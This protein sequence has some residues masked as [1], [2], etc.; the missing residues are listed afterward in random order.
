VYAEL[1]R[2]ARARGT[3]I[4][5]PRE[6]CGKPR[7]VGGATIELL[8]PCPAFVPGRDANDNSL[9]MRVAFGRRTV[10]L[11]G[12]AEALE[13]RELVAR[14][15]GKLRADLLK[16]GHHGSRT[17]TNDALLDAV[18]PAWATISCGVRN[19]FGHPHATVVER[20]ETHGVNALRLDRSGGIV[21]L[22]DGTQVGVTTTTIPH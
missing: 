3:R 12:D 5:G 11:T 20:L 15:G 9:V 22:T 6:L 8:S 21:W 16:V 7:F 13:E 18:R 2:G 17:S 19:R 4:V 10:L 1:V 14:Y